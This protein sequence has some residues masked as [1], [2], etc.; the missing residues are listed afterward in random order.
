[1]HNK[2]LKRIMV[3]NAIGLFLLLFLFVYIINAA[4]AVQSL[5]ADLSWANSQIENTA[6]PQDLRKSWNIL[7]SPATRQG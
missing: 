5:Y 6:I 3:F 4:P 7:F 2:H 1:M